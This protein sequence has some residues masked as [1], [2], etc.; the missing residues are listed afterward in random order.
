MG[1]MEDTSEYS[2][3]VSKYKGFRV[4]AIKLEV[5]GAELGGKQGVGVERVSVT[6]SLDA[7]SAVTFDVVNAYDV[8]SSGFRSEVK[9]L[10]SL[11]AKV[12]LSLGYGSE[13]TCVFQGYISG[14]GASFQDVPALSITAMDVRRL[15]MEGTRRD[16]V[17][18]VTTYS[19]A[20]EEV[21][22]RYGALGASLEVDATD[23]EITQIVQKVSDFEFVSNI[24]TKKAKREFFVL[25]DKVYFREKGKSQSPVTTLKWGEGLTSFSRNSLYQNIKITVIG[26][27]PDNK[28][29]VTAEATQ[30]AVETQ[31][32]VVSEADETVI[33]DADAKEVEKAQKRAEK[34]AQERKRRAQSGS[35]SCI[36]LP[37]IV[38]GRFIKVDGLDSDLNK[39]YYIQ[40]VRHEFGSD[41]F[42]TSF[43]IGGWD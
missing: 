35:A 28:E 34:E 9:S 39:T 27:D 24:L 15:M 21:M 22:D 30:S 37:E 19:A 32:N 36:G 41:G 18:V 7:A 31:K 12:S 42:N 38:P 17:H 25:A 29:T 1:L 4:P 26:F 23:D 8:K 43:E 14:V 11:G 33:Q 16:E 3:L 40:E 20:F 6:L 10:L 2:G 5:D 13:L